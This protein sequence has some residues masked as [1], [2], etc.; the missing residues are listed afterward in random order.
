M[1]LAGV[2]SASILALTLRG[3]IPQNP[4]YHR[5]ADRRSLLGIPNF[6]NVTSNVAFLFAGAAG[7]LAVGRYG[8]SRPLAPAYFVFFLATILLSLGSAYYH[9]APDNRRLTW[10]RLPMA[11]AFMAFLVIVVGERIDPTFARLALPFLLATGA[12]SVAYWHFSELRG[13]GDLRPYLLVQFLPLALATLITLLFPATFSETCGIWGM[14]V[15]YVAAKIAEMLDE[16]I[17]DVHEL[18]SGHTLKHLT[19]AAGVLCQVLAIA[20]RPT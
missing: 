7:L 12:G 3:R 5:F 8:W 17:F 20:G 6:W 13:R 15:A 9:L 19:A 1:V 11:L 10:D 16:R 2:V 18:V 14:L 4:G